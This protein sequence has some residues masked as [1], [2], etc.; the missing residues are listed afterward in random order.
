[1]QAE[2]V[3]VMM[4][5]QLAEAKRRITA[6]KR[7]LANAQLASEKIAAET[8]RTSADLRAHVDTVDELLSA[9]RSLFE[10]LKRKVAAE[11][12]KRQYLLAELRELSQ[13]A[14]R[15]LAKD[16]KSLLDLQSKK[17]IATA[18]MKK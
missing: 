4:H 2:A 13:T 14:S 7:Q 5:G 11:A 1:M 6:Q 9:E 3:G 17:A 10:R 18:E 16:G 8:F 12:E 15:Q